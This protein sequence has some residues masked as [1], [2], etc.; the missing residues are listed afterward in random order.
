MM[1]VRPETEEG[2]WRR[3]GRWRVKAL[4]RRV[5]VMMCTQAEAQSI[6]LIVG[7]SMPSAETIES[8]DSLPGEKEIPNPNSN[9]SFTTLVFLFQSYLSRRR[10]S[11]CV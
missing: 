10:R 5:W 2:R 9:H 11:S 8:S 3:R 4:C 1:K 6:Q 7:I